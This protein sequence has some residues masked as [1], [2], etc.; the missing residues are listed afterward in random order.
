[1]LTPHGQRLSAQS[2]GAR[3]S[4]LIETSAV[5]ESIDVLLGAAGLQRSKTGHGYGLESQ[6]AKILL[7]ALMVLD[8]N[9]TCAELSSVRSF[10]L[11][12]FVS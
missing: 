5:Q 10:S 8:S 4:N 7:G 2:F 12:G 9:I 3:L 11:L 1:V 6:A